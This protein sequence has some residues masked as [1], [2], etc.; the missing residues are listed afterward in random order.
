MVFGWGKKKAKEQ[1]SQ[2]IIRIEKDIHVTEIKPILDEIKSLR[3]KT[4]VAEVKTFRKKIE[5]QLKEILKITQELER[6]NLKVEDIDKHL[7]ILVVRGKKQVI[8][9][10][11]KE[12]NE[13]LPEINSFDD[14]EVLNDLVKQALKRI[15]DILGR[16]SRVIHIFA[17]KY[18]GKL[19]EHLSVLNSDRDEIQSLIDKHLK[20]TEDISIIF[21]KIQTLNQSKKILSETTTRIDDLKKSIDKLENDEQKTEGKIS[22]YKSGDNYSKYLDIKKQLDL[23]SS[24][25]QEIKNLINMQFT[26]ISRPLG[27]YEYAS[28]LEKPEKILL[29]K[30]IANPID[31]ITLENKDL[32]IKILSAVRKGVEGGSISVKDSKKTLSSIDETI[33]T[34][35]DFVSKISQYNESKINLEK[36]LDVF[37]IEDL[38]Q[39]ENFLLKI[40]NEKKENLIKIQK[41]ES[42]IS[43]IKK[44]SPQ[45]M[46]DIEFKLQ[47]VTAT[48]YHIID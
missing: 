10:I 18:A 27:R 37:N 8:E 3:T 5:S 20:M 29:E 47:K 48:K 44:K 43:E 1:E 11:K 46:M 13:N 36:E 39:S 7:E 14:V 31:S 21:G 41:L 6:D 28:S 16:Q 40:L 35:D 25:K 19:K 9:I 2:P 34:L 32:I 15:G 42:E 23:L 22:D 4:I 26:K 33:E 17:K 12:A 24:K 30:L 38:K 45:I